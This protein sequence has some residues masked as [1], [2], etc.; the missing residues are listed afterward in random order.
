MVC[1]LVQIIGILCGGIGMIL[2]W[3]VTLIPQWRVTVIAENTGHLNSRIDG[4]WISRLDG[5]WTTCINHAQI[6]RHCTGYDSEVS[7]TTD[8]KVGRVLMSIAVALNSLAFLFSLVGT[9]LHNIDEETRHGKRCMLLASGIF[10]ILSV[11]LIII[12]VS[13]TI[14]NIVSH[15]CESIVC[16]G[17]VRIEL[18][19]ALFLAW[20][21]IV[22]LLIGGIILCWICPC[23]HRKERHVYVVP[24]DQEMLSRDKQIELRLH[25]NCFLREET[26]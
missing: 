9:L 16:K 25:I 15:T 6:T 13:L 12:P 26:L 10:Y 21:T 2:T 24:R 5:L 7:I 4:Q 3:I 8:L 20:P 18:G 22:F 1:L 23:R 11:I 19:E 14:N 17:S